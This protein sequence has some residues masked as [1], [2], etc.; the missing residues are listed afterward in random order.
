MIECG[1]SPGFPDKK[2]FL[3]R[4]REKLIMKKLEGNDPVELFIQ[5]PVNHPGTA[6]AKLFQNFVVRDN[7]TD[8]SSFS[9]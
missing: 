8:H 2:R 9:F 1:S 7:L 6:F 3:F 5:S 4:I